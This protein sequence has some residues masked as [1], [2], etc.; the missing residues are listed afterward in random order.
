MKYFAILQAAGAA[1]SI[2]TNFKPLK[3]DV[4]TKAVSKKVIHDQCDQ[5]G[6]IWFKY[7]RF[8]ISDSDVDHLEFATILRCW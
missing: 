8:H 1:R 5:E 7:Q 2:E 6:F 3:I 4:H